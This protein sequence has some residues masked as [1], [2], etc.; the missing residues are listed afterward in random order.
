[1]IVYVDPDMPGITRKKVR[2]GWGYWNAKGERITNR[3]EIDRLNKVALPPAYTDA[4]FCPSPHGHIQAIG[5]DARGRR[6]YRYHIDFRARQDAAKYDRLADFGRALPL[7]RAQV[8]RDIAVKPTAHDT[9]VAAVVRLL[10]EGHIRVGNEA[11]AR[12]NKS[13]GA[14]TLRNRHAKISRSALS[15]QYR[16]KS[17][18]MRKLTISDRGLMRVVRRVQDLPGQNLFQYLG[19]DGTPCPVGSADVNAYIKAA[20]GD[21]FSAKH[22]RTWGASV[23]ALEQVITAS[24]SEVRVKI[25]DV[26]APVA[27]ALGNT[28]T[29]ARKSYV[30]PHILGMI[31][32]PVEPVALSRKTRWLSPVERVLIM[33]LD[34]GPKDMSKAA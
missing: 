27:E 18:V 11:Y 12:T 30:H 23:I 16:A 6:Q 28:P 14:T 24:R 20:M 31:G 9:V 34:A 19:E 5:Y 22:F 7:L 10:D 33:L 13:F 26:L 21:D 2:N 15:L 17:G 29:I 32:K 4:W 1:M 3:D 25:A 8:E